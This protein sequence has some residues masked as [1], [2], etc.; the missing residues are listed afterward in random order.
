[1]ERANSGLEA[2]APLVSGDSP[3]AARPSST[4]SAS[5]VIRCRSSGS[6]SGPSQAIALSTSELGKGSRLP[7]LPVASQ[8]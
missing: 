5:A 1:M 3:H 7:K 8:V 2:T 6:S 4:R